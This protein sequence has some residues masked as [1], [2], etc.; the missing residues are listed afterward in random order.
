[1]IAST[2]TLRN[3]PCW[4]LP[5]APDWRA[6]IETR[7]TLPAETERGLTGI[8]SR[9]AYA[10][11]LR[12]EMAFESLLSATQASALRNA[13]QSPNTEQWPIWVPFWPASE[14]GDAFTT[15]RF[16]DIRSS[17]AELVADD[18]IE[19]ADGILRIAAL[20]GFF[21]E[22]PRVRALTDEVFVAQF[23]LR[24]DGPA[25]LALQVQAPTL[26]SGPEVSGESFPV[27]PFQPQWR[28]EVQTGSTRFEVE[29]RELGFNREQARVIYP[30]TPERTLRFQ[31]DL[32]D[33]ADAASL[34]GHFFV[35]AGSTRPF[36]S[37]TWMADVRLTNDP[38]AATSLLE[39]EGSEG[40]GE[41][42]HIAVV[43]S[44]KP[45]AIHEVLEHDATQLVI[46]PPLATGLNRHTAS[47]TTAAL[48]R[49]E[50]PSMTLR[51]YSTAEVSVSLE[52]TECTSDFITDE[53]EVLHST[54]GSLPRACFLYRFS[55]RYP[56]VTKF[57]TFTSYE[58]AIQFESAIYAPKPIE[59]GEIRE[60][61]N[62]E[63]N[64][65]EVRS[66]AF[67]DNPLE[68]FV[69]FRLEFPL[70][71]EIFEGS[72]LDSTL[73]PV[74][75][76]RIFSGEI[77]RVSLDGPLLTARAVT[78]GNLFERKIPRVLLQTACNY[79]L[80]DGGCGLAR[81]NWRYEGAFVSQLLSPT[82]LRVST[83]SKAGASVPIPA[84]HWFAGGWAECGT[85]TGFESRFIADS[86]LVAQPDGGDE[87]ELVLLTDLWN[88]P[89][90]GDPI[91][92]YPGCDGKAATCRDKFSNFSRFGGMP[93]IPVGNPSMVKM[94]ANRNI[95]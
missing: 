91:T 25:D 56:S 41:N 75:P 58:E 22:R 7:F 92:I 2:D 54:I 16:L 68:L 73:A 77:T 87:L 44:G 62:L 11:K 46:S 48:V 47:I 3:E 82:R 51:W 14:G 28:G 19:P 38:Q 10:G 55:I 39:V 67:P 71:L 1:M 70:Q 21:A 79:A 45:V 37:P 40:L 80:F 83:L 32:T 9:R 50:R 52:L 59:H 17:S 30:Q 60:T 74:N 66:R 81:A 4:I 36:W 43:S 15:G 69:P 49:Y 29:G 34:V 89:K 12:T 18:T 13:L 93:F 88:N 53:T 27:F 20:R 57:W 65:I 85:G 31:L 64:E 78:V 76:L 84:D 26:T 35:H 94:P 72:L 6:G 95:K 90:P 5:Y 33:H 8:E 86:R 63:R 23:R 61:L 42:R 24:E